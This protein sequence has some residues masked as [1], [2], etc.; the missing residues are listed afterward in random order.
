MGFVI[1]SSLTGLIGAVASVLAVILTIIIYFLT[2]KKKVLAYEVLSEYPLISI[3][4]QISREELQILY[5]SKPVENVHLLL[6]K[7]VNSGNIPITKSDFERPI[8]LRLKGESNVLSAQT[9]KSSPNNLNVRL[10]I[11]GQDITVD[12]ALMNGGDFF[13]AKVLI[14]QYAIGSYEVDARIVGVKSINRL[15]ARR[16]PHAE[17]RLREWNLGI[18]VALVVLLLVV[19]AVS[20]VMFFG[21]DDD[22]QGGATANAPATV[23][24][25][26]EV[27]PTPGEPT[28]QSPPQE[29]PFSN[30]AAL[31][32][33]A[34][35]E[36]TPYP[37]EIN[38]SG[39]S[40]VIT[41]LTVELR[42]LSHPHM[43][44]LNILLKGPGGQRVILLGGVGGSKDLVSTKI[45]FDDAAPPWTTPRATRNSN[46]PSG[47]TDEFLE[48][49]S[50]PPA[51]ETRAYDFPEV[52]VTQGGTKLSEFD[53]TD[54]NGTWQLYV[55][56]DQQSDH[57]R[58][59]GGWSLTIRTAP[60]ARP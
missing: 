18:V 35:G 12:P 58:I 46:R 51:S 14:G 56:D 27:P 7:F 42:E 57:G 9:I 8:T 5:G 13:T 38:V 4:D 19:S 11:E 54:P 44:D 34:L 17:G 31:K 20:L 23:R 40:G 28:P 26:A 29:Q 32:I 33:N 41:K 3:D 24:N 39:M 47:S 52:E 37:S 60:A 59:A 43:A 15:A 25:F 50:Y 1:D 48:S 16:Q 6:I 45:V 2:R 36:A 10:S 21:D 30:P 55:F 53:G 49:G 22:N